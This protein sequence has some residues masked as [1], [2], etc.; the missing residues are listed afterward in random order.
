MRKPH[1]I[2]KERNICDNDF[3]KECPK[4]S[5]TGF[6]RYQKHLDHLCLMPHFISALQI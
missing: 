1:L 4:Y 6:S 2:D 5:K 3:L